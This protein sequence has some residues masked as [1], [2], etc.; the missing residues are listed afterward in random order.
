M[1]ISF[2][3][4]PTTG[5]LYQSGSSAAYTW[6]GTKWI[7]S[8][9]PVATALVATSLSGSTWVSEAITIT[10]TTSNPTKATTKVD[11][12]IRYRIVGPKEYEVQMMYAHTSAT[13]AAAGNGTYLF[14]LP[15]ALQFNT[16]FNP[17][18]VATT[19]S[20]GTVAAARSVIE[21]SSGFITNGGVYCSSIARVYDS[22]RFM[23]ATHIS[24]GGG[25]T[26][27]LPIA[28]NYFAVNGTANTV[29]SMRFTFT[30]A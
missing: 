14:T 8:T 21:G 7:V 16:T 6:D 28:S 22:T 29:Y 12:Y 10:A 3:T 5:Q 27:N 24:F 11:D 4:S 13:G 15:G 23:I 1:P 26:T 18:Y 19:F 17:G 30:A 25:A 20:D 2:P 9:P